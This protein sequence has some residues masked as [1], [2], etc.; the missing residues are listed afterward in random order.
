MPKTSGASTVRPRVF[1]SCMD[2]ARYVK[3]R[4]ELKK[5]YEFGRMGAVS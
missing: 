3:P 2:G 4:E 5:K 1:G